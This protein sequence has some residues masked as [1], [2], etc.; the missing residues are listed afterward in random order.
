MLS[1]GDCGLG[2]EVASR[3]DL[4]LPLDQAEGKSASRVHDKFE[5][6]A[7]HFDSKMNVDKNV[8]I[9]PARTQNKLCGITFNTQTVKTFLNSWNHQTRQSLIKS[10]PF[11]SIVLK[12]FPAF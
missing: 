11:F 4:M 7:I 5:P 8:P 3:D 12:S 9:L 2:F 10:I 1:D 6:I